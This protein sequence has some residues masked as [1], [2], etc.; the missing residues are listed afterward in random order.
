MSRSSLDN[1]LKL[2]SEKLIAL[3]DMTESALK[4]ALTALKE[5]DFDAANDV[6]RG[7]AEVNRK[8]YELETEVMITIATQSPAARDLRFL[9][10]SLAVC[11]ELERIADYAKRIS[12]VQTR[13]KELGSPSFVAAAYEMGK[14][15]RSML[16]R[17]VRSFI[18]T[19]AE[20]ARR[21][22]PEDDICDAMYENIYADLMKKIAKNS[23]N[24]E[25]IN[26]LLWI[27]HSL[28]RA[29][30]RV[31]NICERAVYVKNGAFD[32]V[33]TPDAHLSI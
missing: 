9:A 22:I 12:K 29:G 32:R 28:E 16:Q 30:D 2:I 26:N 1:D 31:T 5:Y 10:S 13:S 23:R 19:D 7:D 8:R 24:V 20:T 21:I 3:G 27:I 6:I 18:A 33:V 25:Y 15:V 17:A 14:V 4:R 11:S